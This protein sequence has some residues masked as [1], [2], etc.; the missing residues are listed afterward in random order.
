MEMKY[1]KNTLKMRSARTQHLRPGY[2]E[3][4]HLCVLPSLKNNIHSKYEQIMNK[5]KTY[6]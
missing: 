2:Y 5:L 6:G 4:I 1:L 3:K